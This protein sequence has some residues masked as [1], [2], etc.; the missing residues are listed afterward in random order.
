MF[1]VA[2]LVG[3]ALGALVPAAHAATFRGVSI[4]ALLVVVLAAAA[5]WR[6][7]SPEDGWPSLV[8]GLSTVCS[9]WLGLWWEG[10]ERRRPVAEESAAE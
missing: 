8:F 3:I 9:A 4:G 1:V 6:I 5:A 10:R 7:I 2:V